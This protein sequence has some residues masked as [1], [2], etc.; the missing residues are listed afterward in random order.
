MDAKKYDRIADLLMQIRKDI[1]NYV[2]PTHTKGHWT[3]QVYLDRINKLLDDTDMMAH[4]DTK[5][6]L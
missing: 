6:L 2:H 1:A 4:H 5:G 3:K